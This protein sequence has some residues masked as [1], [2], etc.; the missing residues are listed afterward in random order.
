MFGLA[1][2]GLDALHSMKRRIVRQ[3]SGVAREAES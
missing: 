3:E 2:F 1:R